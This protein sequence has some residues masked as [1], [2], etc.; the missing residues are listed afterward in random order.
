MSK[1]IHAEQLHLQQVEILQT[2]IE[3]IPNARA[4]SGQ[5]FT[6]DMSF[7]LQ[8]AREQE[9]VFTILEVTVTL[10]AE[11]EALANSFFKFSFRFQVDQLAD[12]ISVEKAT[13]TILCNRQLA[14][15]LAAISFSTVRGI[16]LTHFQGT[17]F[18][19]FILPIVNPEQL[20]TGQ[21]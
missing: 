18:K 16:L 5:D 2:R 6:S 13:K 7:Q 11:E 20:L 17:I 12:F 9:V 8:V 19:D 3:E 21:K 1:P 15:T 14:G 10:F 4:K